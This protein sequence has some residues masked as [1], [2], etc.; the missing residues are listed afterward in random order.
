MDYAGT[1][2]LHIERMPRGGGRQASGLDMRLVHQIRGRRRTV[3]RWVADPPA[4]L[5]QV[6]ATRIRSAMRGCT[7]GDPPR[8]Q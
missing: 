1:Q 4:Y 7:V 8:P 6:T 5:M 3:I 2:I